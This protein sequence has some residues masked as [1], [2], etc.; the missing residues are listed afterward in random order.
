MALPSFVR[1]WF[2]IRFGATLRLTRR[3]V[4][5]LPCFC[6]PVKVVAK[7]QRKKIKARD[8]RKQ[9][10]ANYFGVLAHRIP[11]L[12]MLGGA[13]LRVEESMAYAPEPLKLLLKEPPRTTRADSFKML[14]QLL[15][16][17]G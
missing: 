13:S 4:P 5:A 1:Y 9:T 15:Q 12:G 7:E 8:N 2:V 11:P 6:D 14:A 10:G 3:R 16:G 17:I